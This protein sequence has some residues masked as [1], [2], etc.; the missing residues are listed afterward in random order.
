MHMGNRAFRS[1]GSL[2]AV[3]ATVVGLSAC[4]GS[5]K[6]S[7]S[8]FISKCT[9]DKDLSGAVSKIPGGAGK[10][11]SLCHCVQS[12]L[13]AGGFG[14]KTTDDSSAAVKNAGRDAGIACAQ[15]ILAGG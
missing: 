13:V 14:D 4:G 7:S 9:S 2:L 6:I 11:D 10:L 15:Q 5:P 8:D 12:K 1:A 3:S